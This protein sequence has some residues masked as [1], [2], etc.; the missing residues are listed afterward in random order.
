MKIVAGLFFT[1]ARLYCVCSPVF[2]DSSTCRW[3]KL[4]G[5]I[6]LQNVYADWRFAVVPEEC[7]NTAFLASRQMTE[8]YFLLVPDVAL[9]LQIVEFSP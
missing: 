6:A 9:V 8:D 4:F 7:Q 5:V 2:T 1:V 3:G